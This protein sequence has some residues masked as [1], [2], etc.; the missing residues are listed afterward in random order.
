MLGERPFGQGGFQLQPQCSVVLVLQPRG[1]VRG[2]QADEG[3]EGG[4]VVGL[5]QEVL[6]DNDV[7]D[8]VHGLFVEFTFHHVAYPLLLLCCCF[9]DFRQ[10][11]KCQ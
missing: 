5:G 4:N 8:V 10:Q 6:C 7:E 1:A 9:L 3:E 2:L 11:Q